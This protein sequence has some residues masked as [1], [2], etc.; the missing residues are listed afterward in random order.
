LHQDDDATRPG[1]GHRVAEAAVLLTVAIWSA[2]FV[3]VKAAIGVFGPLTFTSLRW[4]VAVVTLFMILRWRSGAIRWP[5]RDG[6]ILLGLGVLGFGGYQVLWTV[7][8]TQITAGDSAL[9]IAASPVLVALLAG[10]VGLDRLTAPKL[11]GAVVAFGGVAVV[12][13]TGHE[14]TLG[15]SLVGD[16]LTLAAAALW[17]VYT[18]AGAQLLRRIDP[19]EATAWSVLG[20]ALFL[21]PFGA[22]EAAITPPTGI[23]PAAMLAVLY[24]GALAAAIANVIVFNAIRFVGPTRVTAMQFLVP[25]GAV[26]LGAIALAEPVRPAQVAGGAVIVA[27][28]W[29]TRR[30]SIVPD[31]VRARVAHR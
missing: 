28:V 19:L 10:A 11:A 4:V 31:A 3:V 25:A 7:G 24:S 13:A 27:G 21:V 1:S 23:T 16:V 26:V 20:G 9:I 30:R 2:N 12:I 8:L 15:S 17:A 6:L 5:G 22:W 29:L 14:L 18:T